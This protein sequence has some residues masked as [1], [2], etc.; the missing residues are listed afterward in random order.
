MRSFSSPPAPGGPSQGALTTTELI[1][2]IVVIVVAAGLAAFGIP[3]FGALE[4]IAGALY[5]A[6][7]SVKAM[8]AAEV[9]PLEAV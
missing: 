9:P 4:F 3:V 5:V 2:V 6:C 7:R 1:V 8:R